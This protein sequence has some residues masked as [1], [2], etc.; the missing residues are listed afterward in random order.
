MS[1]L[2]HAK[3]SLQGQVHLDCFSSID[4][5][6]VPYRQHYKRR[7][8]CF[9]TQTDQRVNACVTSY[10]PDADTLTRLE[11]T[12]CSIALTQGVRH[13]DHRWRLP[14]YLPNDGPE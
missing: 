9:C 12:L 13:R 3:A 11:P 6:K 10:C 1:I 14:E 2:V 8:R 5:H 7:A 4:K